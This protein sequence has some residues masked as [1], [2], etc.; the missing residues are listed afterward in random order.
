MA[1]ELPVYPVQPAFSRGEV[2]PFLFGRVDLAGWSQGLRT[3][4]NATVRPEGCVMNRQGFTFVD[5]ALTNTPLASI[6]VPF[7]FNTTQSY[8]LEI[9]NG[10]A[11]V[12]SAGALVVNAGIP[13]TFSTPWAA[14]DLPRL[15]WSQSADTLTLVHPN[16]PPFEIKRTSA[17]SFTC[18]QAVYSGGPFLQQ[19]ADG[20]TFVHASAKSGTVTLTASAPIFNANHVGALFQLTQQDLSVIEPWEPTKQFA[21]SSIIGQY[22]RA[23]LKNYLAV[24][25]VSTSPGT[26]NATGTWIPS[27]SQGVQADGDG[28]IIVNVGT[29]GVNWLYQ[30]SGVGIVLITGFTSSTQVTGVVQ[31]NY[32]GGPGLLPIS[33]VGGPQVVE[34]PFNFTGDGTTTSFGPLSSSTT[35]DQTKYFVTIGGVYQSPALYT[36]T[37]AG[38]NIVFI[39]APANGAAIVVS[40]ISALGQTTFWAFG[41]FSKDQGYPSAV[42]YFPDRLV[43]AGTPQQPV[44]VFGSVTSQYHQFTVSN[45][46]VASDSFAVFLNAR[47]LNAITD[48]IPLSDLLVGTTNIIWRLWP[49]QTGIALS[50]LAIASTPQSYYGECATCASVLFG[51]SAIFPEY[52]GRRLRDL[53]Y[54]FAFDKFMGQELTL[55]SRHLIPFGTQFKRLAYKP[56]PSGQLVFGLLTSG[57]LLVCTYLREQQIIGWGHFDTQGTFEDICVVPEN[58]VYNLY[59]IIR[60]VINGQT[61]RYV[62]QLGSR[63]VETIY[64]Y[65]FLDCNLTYDGRNTSATTM[66]ATGGTTWQATDT[67]TVSASS[68][69]GWA[70]FQ[71]TDVGNEIWLYTTLTFQNSVGG[72]QQGTLTQQVTPGSYPVSFS[73]GETR[74]ITVALDGLTVT[75]Q[76]PLLVGEITSCTI[77]VRC[78]I[79]AVL[80]PTQ[81]NVTFKDPVPTMLQGI[82][83]TVWAFARS[84][85]SGASQIANQPVVAYADANVLGISAAGIS[86]NGSVTVNGAGMVRL[87]NP[88]A[89]VQIGLPYLSDFETLPLNL[90]GQQTLRMRAKT[91]PV[92]YLD[93]AESRNFL[94]G[95]DFWNLMPSAQRAF[96]TYVAPIGQQQG[97]S[98][99]RVPTQLDSECHTCIRQ[100]MPLPI[101]IRAVIPQVGVGEPVS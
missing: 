32:V 48:L 89:V 39:N 18:M 92:I 96:E 81:A 45:P 11:Q 7:V 8:A 26:E 13:I 85:F 80:S 38:G 63:E 87:P 55:Y 51:D 14:A 21:A 33:V 90:P 59:A 79:T 58:A 53:I 83:V 44:G 52:D 37:G 1:F 35:T 82:G 78:S 34:G 49:G 42:S 70:N 2:S 93:V 4:R 56:D 43:L 28:Q 91:E 36:I 3:L 65:K 15:R 84:T 73:D 69:S 74:L 17:N 30:D 41:A 6:L 67:G 19:N 29:S 100:N 66:T 54:Q 88:C 25:L 57:A 99:T 27:H 97:V 40:Q 20:V 76:E 95:N 50:P 101:T 16:Y 46:V 22:R 71:A 68:T 24:S 60:R 72:I 98:W 62:E 64:D 23:S 31:P 5:A 61:V 12:F 9:G 94:A 75:W 47:Q 77:R 86:P 10:S